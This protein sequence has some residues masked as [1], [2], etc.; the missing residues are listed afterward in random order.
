M[1]HVYIHPYCHIMA[2]TFNFYSHIALSQEQ[3][4]PVTWPH[5]VNIGGSTRSITGVHLIKIEVAQ[6]L[7][8]GIT[9]KSFP[10]FLT[11]I[12]ANPT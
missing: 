7:G 4:Y 9:S 6:P 10:S 1:R 3:H 12:L 2:S 11:G 8:C 5:R